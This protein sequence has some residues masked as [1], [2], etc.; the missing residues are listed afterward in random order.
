MVKFEIKTGK[1][2]DMPRILKLVFMNYTETETQLYF[3]IKAKEDAKKLCT[4]VNSFFS[5]V[6]LRIELKY[7]KLFKNLDKLRF[8]VGQFN[9]NVI[10]LVNLGGSEL[11]YEIMKALEQINELL[12]YPEPQLKIKMSSNLDFKYCID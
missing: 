4:S 1:K 3:M 8:R 6:M 11:T 9:Q 7:P 2:N 10:L 5:N 12:R